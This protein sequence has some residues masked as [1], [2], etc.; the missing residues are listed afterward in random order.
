MAQARSRNALCDKYMPYPDRSDEQ[1]SSIIIPAQPIKRRG[2]GAYEEPKLNDRISQ[3]RV[4]VV[5]ALEIVYDWLMKAKSQEMAI[6]FCLT[7]S[8][9]L[10]PTGGR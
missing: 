8:V 4:S 7:L 2:R 1:P 6:P 3:V 9:P 5:P 10:Q